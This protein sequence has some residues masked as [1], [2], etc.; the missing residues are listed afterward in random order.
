MELLFNE[1]SYYPLAT[2]ILEAENRFTQLMRTFKE[3]N[4]TFGFK[5]IQF[6]SNHSEQLITADKTFY[7]TISSLSKNDLLMI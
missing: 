3:A 4:V 1:L 2:S 7:Q 5:K 6:H